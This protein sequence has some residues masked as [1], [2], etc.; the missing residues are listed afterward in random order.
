MPRFEIGLV[1]V[2]LGMWRQGDGSVEAG[3]D[4]GGADVPESRGMM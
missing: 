1:F 2:A 4:G 3:G